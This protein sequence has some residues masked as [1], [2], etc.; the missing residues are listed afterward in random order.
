MATLGKRKERK[1]LTLYEVTGAFVD[2]SVD[3]ESTEEE[4]S[5]KLKNLEMMLDEKVSNGIGLIRNWKGDVDA[6]DAEIKRLTQ[7]K[8]TFENRIASVKNYYLGELS[9]IGK[10]K[11]VTPIGAMTV[12]KAGGK[13]PLKIDDE[14][15]IPQEFKKIIYE[16]DK[17]KIR[18]AL[19]GGAD[20]SGVHLEERGTYLKIS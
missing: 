8:K 3:D 14:T 5:E 4:F 9:A 13:K 12:A 6:I 19:E 15:L 7:R 11:V 20:I 2:L 18:T 17:E 16:P 1:I 10:K